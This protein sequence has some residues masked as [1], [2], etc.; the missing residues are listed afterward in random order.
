MRFSPDGQYILAQEDFRI[1]VLTQ[2]P[3]RALFRI[4][5]EGP[6]PAEFTP[7]SRQIVFVS[8]A[9]S[10]EL[11]S[12][13]SLAQVERWSIADRTRIG[14]AEI[15]LHGCD[16]KGLSPDG[17]VLACVDFDG[18]LRLLDV[19]SGET[20]FEKKRFGKPIVLW[21][22]D[23][24][25]DPLDLFPRHELGDPGSA[26]IDFSPDGRFFLAL[27]YDADG[28]AFAF[29]LTARRPIALSRHV[30]GL[31]MW[32]DFAFVAP[33]HLVISQVRIGPSRVTATLIA[34]P[35][36]RVLSKTKIPPGPVFRAADARF[37]LVRPCGPFPRRLD[38][39]W[40]HVK[41]TGACE[42]RT[43]QLTLSRTPALD[44]FGGHFV[45]ESATGEI[46]LYE[47][48]KPAAIATVSLDA[49]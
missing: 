39:D 1:T 49:H 12:S 34:F 46:G 29:D 36:G 38:S 5:A 26:K 16:S 13:T 19:A 6:S 14:F 20:I 28:S 24:W 37:V 25:R 23:Q 21:V 45:A 44:V 3:F 9:A 7:D 41:K 43:G 30:R 32:H 35:S 47:R 40:E 22:E 8:S 27:P 10:L 2:R 48:G 11:A 31:I 15:R 18:T 42:L 4:P 17:L 33:G